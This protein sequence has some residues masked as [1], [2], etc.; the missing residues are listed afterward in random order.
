[1]EAVQVSLTPTEKQNFDTC[2]KQIFNI[3]KQHQPDG[4]EKI[5]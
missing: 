3:A 4:L 5:L 2:N 1:V